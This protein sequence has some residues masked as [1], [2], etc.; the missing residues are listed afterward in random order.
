MFGQVSRTFRQALE[1]AANSLPDKPGRCAHQKL[2]NTFA[3]ACEAQEV[4]R[5]GVFS[6]L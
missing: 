6:N 3:R 2:P 1:L 5:V 4:A